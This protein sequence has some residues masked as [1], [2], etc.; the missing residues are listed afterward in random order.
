MISP[1]VESTCNH[2]E[3]VDESLRDE[4]T[5]LL[6][7]NKMK[8]KLVSE[9]QTEMQSMFAEEQ[10]DHRDLYSKLIASVSK[11]ADLKEEHDVL[12]RRELPGD[13]RWPD[14]LM[15]NEI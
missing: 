2:L 7:Q 14:G 13:H 8:E 12:N 4:E 11:I 15:S 3:T 10:K 9:Q 5:K 1:G 6:V